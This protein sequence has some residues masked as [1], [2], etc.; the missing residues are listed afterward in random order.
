MAGPGMAWLCLASSLPLM[1]IGNLPPW[2]VP[3]WFAGSHYPSWGS[4]TVA[5][6]ELVEAQGVKLITPHGD[7]EPREVPEVRGDGVRGSLPLMGIGNIAGPAIG[8]VSREP[9]FPSWGSGTWTY[10][11]VTVPSVVSLPLMGIGNVAQ[12]RGG[13]LQSKTHYP[14]WGS[15]T[16]CWRPSDWL[17]GTSLPLMGIGNARAPSAGSTWPWTSH[18]PSWGSGTRRRRRGLRLFDQLI[19]P[20][21]DRERRHVRG[22]EGG[23]LPL[24]TPHGDRERAQ[25]P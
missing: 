7:R 24:I 22:L 19:T 2:C 23:R 18:Y 1:G 16:F 13:I 25:D 11:K 17:D 6:G 14:S 21:G 15:G 20:H 3:P 5:A 10:V 4:G 8:A 9:H 12:K